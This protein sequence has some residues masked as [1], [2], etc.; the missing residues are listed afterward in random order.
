[1]KTIIERLFHEEYFA[2]RCQGTMP[3]IEHFSSRVQFLLGFE[4]LQSM[5]QQYE[6]RYGE[7]HIKR[8]ASQGFSPELVSVF[9]KPAA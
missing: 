7:G 5:I 1:M 9:S 4:S 8:L 3:E 2:L 6:A